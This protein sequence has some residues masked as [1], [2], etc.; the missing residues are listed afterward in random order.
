MEHAP[1]TLA[2][3]IE[4]KVFENPE[5]VISTFKDEIN[6]FNIGE[7]NKKA[8]LLAKGLSYN[9]VAKDTPVALMLAGTTN[10][11]TVVLALAKIGALLIPLNKKMKDEQI[12]TILRDEKIHTLGFY[13]DDFL[14]RLNKIIPNFEENERG[15]LRSDSYTNLRNLV[16][17]GSIK[18]RGIFT[19]REL[20][21]L[22]M[23]SDDTE[24]ELITEV[25]SPE[26]T[27]IKYIYWDTK[28]K[29]I[30]REIKHGEI[31]TPDFT[32]AAFQNLLLSFRD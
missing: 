21:L 24:L 25:I 18:K 5:E 9:N 16:T 22:G 32:I 15:Y 12:I 20:M 29:K 2:G 31:V 19:T 30:I 1:T 14:A 8:T 28:N 7:L 13:A 10:C 27:F 3:F 26:D 4:Q 17:F 6:V 11:L 23:H